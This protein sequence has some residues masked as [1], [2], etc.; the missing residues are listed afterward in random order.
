[1]QVY[2]TAN[3]VT[4]SVDGVSRLMVLTKG[5][6]SIDTDGAPLFLAGVPDSFASD[7]LQTRGKSEFSASLQYP[8][9]KIEEAPSEMAESKNI[10]P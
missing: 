3:V 8:S 1:M 7:A 4:M 9:K 5:D 2:K 10:V 6:L